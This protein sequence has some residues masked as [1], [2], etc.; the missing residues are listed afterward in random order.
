MVEISSP[1]LD[2]ILIHFFAKLEYV[3][4]KVTSIIFLSS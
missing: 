4:H 3:V 1:K 2:N